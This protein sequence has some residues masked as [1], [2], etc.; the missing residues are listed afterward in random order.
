MNSSV[1]R[2]LIFGLVAGG[3]ILASLMLIGVCASSPPLHLVLFGSAKQ[4]GDNTLPGFT[5]SIGGASVSISNAGP[6]EILL[7]IESQPRLVRSPFVSR[8]GLDLRPGYQLFKQGQ[9]MKLGDYLLENS[10]R[11]FHIKAMTRGP[12]A[13]RA[14]QSGLDASRALWITWDHVHARNVY[15]AD[16][17]LKFLGRIYNFV[18]TIDV[19][20][21]DELR[22]AK[23][24]LIHLKDEPDATPPIR[25]TPAP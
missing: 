15:N 18:K 21:P 11:S 1:K 12:F 9:V 10:D 7:T 17:K 8:T 4:F 23:Q 6:E 25:P 13:S 24:I 22:E 14:F 16:M 5:L 20:P 2:I 3:L 19:E